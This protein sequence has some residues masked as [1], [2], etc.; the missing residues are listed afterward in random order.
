MGS[1]SLQTWSSL[2]SAELDEIETVAVQEGGARRGGRAAQQLLRGYT[3]LLSA[4]FQGFGRD[5]HSE[6]VD[7]LIQSISP[8]PLR[9]IVKDEFLWNRRLDQGNPTPGNIGSDF[10][11]LGI[12]FWREADAVSATAPHWRLQLEE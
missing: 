2:R 10:G 5:L 3:L 11:R 12:S 1:V 8:G 9:L 4:Q 7:A 6:C